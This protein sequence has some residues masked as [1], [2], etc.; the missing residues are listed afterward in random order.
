VPQEGRLWVGDAAEEGIAMYKIT[1]FLCEA[2]KQH[3]LEVLYD[4]PWDKAKTTAK[5]TAQAYV[6]SVRA[7]AVSKLTGQWPKPDYDALA[8]KVTADIPDDPSLAFYM[9]FGELAEQELFTDWFL[10]KFFTEE[11]YDNALEDALEAEAEEN[12]P[13]YDDRGMPL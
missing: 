3:L 5:K 8:E 11:D 2:E 12:E 1:L 6:D 13:L 4:N 7:L 10:G 9:I